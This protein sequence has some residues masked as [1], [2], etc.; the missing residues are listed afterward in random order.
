MS[1]CGRLYD[2]KRE[3]NVNSKRNKTINDRR[4]TIIIKYRKIQEQDMSSIACRTHK[5][6]GKYNVGE[7]I[8]CRAAK[9]RERAG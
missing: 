6:Q 7:M 5:R 1:E 2:S 8:E 3:N 9:A 4:M